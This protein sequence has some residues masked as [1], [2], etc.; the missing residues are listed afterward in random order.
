MNP[1]AAEYKTHPCPADT[2]AVCACPVATDTVT[3]PVE[4]AGTISLVGLN[5]QVEYAGNVP[6]LKVKVPV[7]PLAGVSTSV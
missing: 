2:E 5:V 6:H 7:E 1:Q 3:F 4:L